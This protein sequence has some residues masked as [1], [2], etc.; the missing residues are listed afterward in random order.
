MGANDVTRTKVHVTFEDGNTKVCWHEGSSALEKCVC[1]VTGDNS[2]DAYKLTDKSYFP[3]NDAGRS[4]NDTNAFGLVYKEDPDYKKKY[5]QADDDAFFKTQVDFGKKKLAELVDEV[6]SGGHRLSMSHDCG[7]HYELHG[8]DVRISN[9]VGQTLGGC[10]VTRVNGIFKEDIFDVNRITLLADETKITV[11]DYELYNPIK[12]Q[13][14]RLYL[15]L[16]VDDGNIGEVCPYGR[17][18][19]GSLGIHI[20]R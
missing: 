14:R 7:D 10:E 6:K 15:S 12:E 8:M 16:T 3:L 4:A 2:P 11:T 20:S 5:S 13:L 18:G 1:D 9:N 19:L 17:G